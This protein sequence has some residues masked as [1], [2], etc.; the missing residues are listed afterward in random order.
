[1]EKRSIPQKHFTK[2]AT[3]LPSATKGKLIRLP[4]NGSNSAGSKATHDL[5]NFLIFRIH[6]SI[7]SPGLLS[8]GRIGAGN[9]SNTSLKRQGIKKVIPSLRAPVPSQRQGA[10]QY[11]IRHSWRVV[12]LSSLMGK[13]ILARGVAE[14]QMLLGQELFKTRLVDGL[15]VGFLRGN[16]ALAEL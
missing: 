13:R 2:A 4:P 8:A 14:M 3:T 7:H 6:G 10:C 9:P 12:S 16:H 1:M 11:A 15:H 5:R